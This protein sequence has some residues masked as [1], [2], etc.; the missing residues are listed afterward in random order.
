M[1][2]NRSNR[3]A[4]RRLGAS[5]RADVVQAQG[6]SVVLPRS[7]DNGLG[8]ASYQLAKEQ[9]RPRMIESVAIASIPP[10]PHPQAIAFRLG[11]WLVPGRRP[12]QKCAAPP[13]GA[14]S[15]DAEARECSG[16]PGTGL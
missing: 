7:R 3:E 5:L 16:S 15:L 12:H 6:Y 10:D 14:P 1:K 2:N 9:C 13:C 8:T 11:R 4:D